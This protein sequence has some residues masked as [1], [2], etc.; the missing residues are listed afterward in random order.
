[1]EIHP[2]QHYIEG[3][4]TENAA[5]IREVY[6]AFFPDI[7]RFILKNRGTLSDAHDVFQEGMYLLHH[8][9]TNKNF[10]IRS[11]LNNWFFIVCRNVWYQNLN[12]KAKMPMTSEMK[13]DIIS[14]D[15][16]LEEKLL[17]Q[18]RKALY[19]S[20]FGELTEGCQK[21]L[22]LFFEKIK[23]SEIAQKMGYSNANVAKKK[24]SL[25][26]KKLIELIVADSSYREL[27]T[28]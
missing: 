6:D 16:S 10:V 19:L 13:T 21:V 5:V 1:M 25:C 24:K 23:M 4:R 8:E 9:I 20:K 15:I 26:Q 3:I 2:H 12:K 27:S 22:T 17:E 18:Q 28:R 11:G 14:E 7:K